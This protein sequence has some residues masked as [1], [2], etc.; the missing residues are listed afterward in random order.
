M[1]TPSDVVRS[2][3]V[4][5]VG[6]AHGLIDDFLPLYDAVERHETHVAASMERVYA[7]LRQADL[8]ASP[9][10]RLLLAL[11]ALPGRRRRESARVRRTLTLDEMCRDGFT[12][13]AE[14]PPC[15]IVLGLAGKF[16]KA[17]SGVR[18]IADADSFRR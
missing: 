2:D 10:V 6:P 18:R 9:I 4:H 15:E 13:L 11:R 3:D 7:A 14:D 5:A 8:A 12:L 1:V 16:W 17:A